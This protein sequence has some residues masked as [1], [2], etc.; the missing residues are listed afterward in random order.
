MKKYLIYALVLF[1]VVSCNKNRA[2]IF[3]ENDIIYLG[4]VYFGETIN[5]SIKIENLGDGILE[6]LNVHADCGCTVPEISNNKIL[7]N[8]IEYIKFSFHP[9]TTGHVQQKIAIKNNSLNHPEK[10]VLIRA[11]VKF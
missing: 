11:L 3:F 7:P 8:K 2:E 4:E 9:N 10:I 6:I 1:L 5:D